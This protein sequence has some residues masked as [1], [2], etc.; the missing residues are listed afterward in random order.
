MASIQQVSSNALLDYAMTPNPDPLQVSPQ[1]GT[2]EK[3]MLTLA[4]SSSNFDPIDLYGITIQIPVGDE[5]DELASV[6][7]GIG[8]GL[9]DPSTWAGN[10]DTNTN[11]L[12]VTP[13]PSK[14][15]FVTIEE[16]GLFITLSNISI[17]AQVGVAQVVVGENSAKEAGLTA[18]MPQSVRSVIY[19]VSKFPE[20]FYLNYFIP[21]SGS[22]N[23]GD[24]VGLSWDGSP[25]ARYTLSYDSEVIDVTGT[26]SRQIAGLQD[27][28]TFILEASMTVGGSTATAKK[29]TTVI[30]R[31]DEKYVPQGLIALWSTAKSGTHI[32]DGWVI[33]DGTDAR[34]PNLASRFIVA[35]NSIGTSEPVD[36]FGQPSSHRHSFSIAGQSFK[37]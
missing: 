11:T 3:G 25:D 23:A 9:S 13:Q 24:T 7:T 16:D 18:A 14:G 8:F 37:T 30:V 1:S 19:D 31:N 32:P 26:F 27:D 35:A 28:T 10:F 20:Q 36:A 5:A 4:I 21:D 6:N 17:N 34:A 12:T 22:V 15:A 33:C 29:S 2:P